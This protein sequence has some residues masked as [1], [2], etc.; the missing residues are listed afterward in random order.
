MQCITHNVVHS[1]CWGKNS[2]LRAPLWLRT[3]SQEVWVWCLV[4]GQAC[5]MASWKSFNL[6]ALGLLPDKETNQNGYLLPSTPREAMENTGVLISYRTAMCTKLYQCRTHDIYPMLL[7]YIYYTRWDK[8]KTDLFH[9][10]QLFKVKQWNAHWQLLWPVSSLLQG[11]N[12]CTS[13][14]KLQIND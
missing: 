13:C 8:S 9:S 3:P 2:L 14:W 6:W 1:E 11:F 7:F 10:I 4:P 12:N 5:F